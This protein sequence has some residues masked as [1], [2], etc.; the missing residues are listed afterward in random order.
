MSLLGPQ[1]HYPLLIQ[2]TVQDAVIIPSQYW[3]IGLPVLVSA[4]VIQQYFESVPK[5]P[6]SRWSE[7]VL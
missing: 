2:N 6:S 7:F 1:Y 4:F 5:L 3:A